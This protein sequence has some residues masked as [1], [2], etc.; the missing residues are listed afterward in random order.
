MRYEFAAS[1]VIPFPVP[2]QPQVILRA[3]VGYRKVGDTPYN[4]LSLHT[5]KFDAESA[6]QALVFIQSL[7]LS[8]MD[9][10][11]PAPQLQATPPNQTEL[12]NMANLIAKEVKEGVFT[13]DFLR[14]QLNSID[15]T[16]GKPPEST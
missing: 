14:D 5:S 15:W 12:E 9:G 6:K 2:G 10:P 4:R 16:G 8:T 13:P 1:D 3:V 11:R 7:F